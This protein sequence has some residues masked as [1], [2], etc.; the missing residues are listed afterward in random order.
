ML[1]PRLDKNTGLYSVTVGDV[2]SDYYYFA[3]MFNRMSNSV[4]S[5]RVWRNVS[6]L[7]GIIKNIRRD[8]LQNIERTISQHN[9]GGTMNQEENKQNQEENKHL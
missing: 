5:Q 7:E 1:S 3:T 2:N 6:L 9:F 4:Y 8:Y